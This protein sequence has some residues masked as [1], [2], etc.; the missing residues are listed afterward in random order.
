MN[1]LK[2][3]DNKP[4]GSKPVLFLSESN[5]LDVGYFINGEI[6]YF[7]SEYGGIFDNLDPDEWPITHFLEVDLPNK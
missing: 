2:Y 6:P 5:G 7:R 3:P 4:T 1:W